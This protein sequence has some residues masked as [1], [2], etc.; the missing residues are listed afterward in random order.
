M[1]KTFIIELEKIHKWIQV[2]KLSINIDK[3]N[4]VIFRCKNNCK[5]PNLNITINELEMVNQTKCLGLL[6][7]KTLLQ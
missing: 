3:T 2:N 7:A 1:T 6:M 4:Y 5:V